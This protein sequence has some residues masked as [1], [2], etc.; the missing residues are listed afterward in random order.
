MCGTEALNV[1]GTTTWAVCEKGGFN[2]HGRKGAGAQR[3]P[4]AC[5]TLGL[6]CKCNTPNHLLYGLYLLS[7]HAQQCKLEL[8]LPFR[9]R[10]R[11]PATPA[12][13]APQLPSQPFC[14]QTHCRG[15]VRHGHKNP[16]GFVSGGYWLVMSCEP[17][18]ET[19]LLAHATTPRCCWHMP[20]SSPSPLQAN[21][22]A[23]L[24]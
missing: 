18:H 20:Q 21:L 11:M 16:R 14:C 13:P 17:T 2:G 24:D 3:D 12:P 6:Q 4:T 19:L 7:E 1:Q 10:V 15:T 8:S 23:S 5:K 22:C 9:S